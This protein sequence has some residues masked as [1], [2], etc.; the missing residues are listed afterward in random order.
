LPK[1]ESDQIRDRYLENASPETVY[2][3]M[4]CSCEA[5]LEFSTKRQIYYGNEFSQEI[6]IILK[7]RED[8]IIDLALAKFGS[9][10]DVKREFFLRKDATLTEAMLRSPHRDERPIEHSM[11]P[12]WI[13]PEEFQE[14]LENGVQTGVLRAFFTNPKIAPSELVE[15]FS[16]RGKYA[17]L[18]DER[19]AT[20]I[21][22]GL[23]N[24]V[25]HSFP[26][27]N[28]RFVTGITFGDEDDAIR[29]AWEAPLRLAN[30]QNNANLLAQGLENI[31]KFI[32]P[33]DLSIIS[34]AEDPVTD[35]SYLD[36]E[37]DVEEAKRYSDWMDE[38]S[39][40]TERNIVRYLDHVFQKWNSANSDYEEAANESLGELQ[41]LRDIRKITAKCAA[42]GDANTQQFLINHPNEGVRSG[43]YEGFELDRGDTD[44]Y[45]KYLNKDGELFFKAFVKNPSAF[46]K[47]NKEVVK[48]FHYLIM[49]YGLD[50]SGYELDSWDRDFLQLEYERNRDDCFRR[51]PYNYPIF[52]EFENSDEDDEVISGWAKKLSGLSQFRELKFHNDQIKVVAEAISKK[53]SN[54]DLASA[55]RILSE[56]LA[57][58]NDN[59]LETTKGLSRLSTYLDEK[60]KSLQVLYMNLLKLGALVA[61]VIIISIWLG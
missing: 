55:S 61:A 28:F 31:S 50:E 46:H 57:A 22:Y 54:K 45:N 29:G 42:N 38:Y 40:A 18:G 36:I 53:G 4:E 47:K 11:I 52:N 12:R 39:S 25:L 32:C 7:N 16:S 17:K 20:C 5:E 49:S 60:Y 33:H 35:M 59:L 8:P 19:Y 48:K 21:Y 44:T 26:E 34:G 3:Y 14:M 30:T 37:D 23:Q 51:D 43:Y 13:E 24:P 15:L 9:N 6:Q 10:D 41:S 27:P 1:F 58:V 56:M 2:S